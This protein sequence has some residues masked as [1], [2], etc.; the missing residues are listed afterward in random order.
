MGTNIDL[1]KK[2]QEYFYEL[3]GFSLRAERFF[4]EFKFESA[5]EQK[6]TQVWIE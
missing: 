3:E 2:F 4:D 6:I 1:K 5:Q